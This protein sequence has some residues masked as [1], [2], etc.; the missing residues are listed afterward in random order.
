VGG[1]RAGL[2]W[3][4]ILS[5]AGALRNSGFTRLEWLEETRKIRVVFE[6]LT[7]W[8]RSVVGGLVERID[9]SLR[10]V[11][12]PVS[13]VGGLLRDVTR[14]RGELLAEN[15]ALRQQLIV[16]A[17]TVKN[18]K[19][20]P[21]ERGL[22]VLLARFAPHWRD[23]MLL[24][25]PETVLRWHREGFRLFW[26]VRSR[27]RARSTPRIDAETSEFIAR[28]ARENRLWGAERVRGELLKIG[29][30]VSKRTIQK[31]MRRVRGPAPWGQS[32]S[33]FL[34]NHMHQTWACDF[35]QL[36]DFWFRPIFAFFIIDLGARRV[37][38]VGVTRNPSTTWVAQ[39]IRNATPCGEGPRFLIRD[40]DDKFGI[41]FDRAAKGAGVRV[42]RTGVRA[43]RMNADCERFLG[44][45]R[46]DCVDH[47][48]VLGERHLE[49][50]LQ[51][52]CFRYFNQARPHQG[53][54]Q[55][56]PIGSANSAAGR[57]EV[58]SVSVL[59]GLHH[60]Y[61]RAA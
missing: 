11:T 34:R 7:Q 18:P 9:R 53:M 13:L 60:D 28:L 36:Y 1:T 35:L 24:V 14:S 2:S 50:V 33:T 5:A 16:V 48:L 30:Q 15:M 55:L 47:V 20:A 45:A 17:R 23:A 46:R 32:W 43:P 37:V 40:N 42:L 56:V 10:S 39:Q 25:K 61:Q 27:A 22:L 49:R 8:V 19:V 51:E 12:R 31:Y 6:M 58:V 59:N 4:P 3:L 44:S 57:G 29:V 21:V 52:Y 54:G 41:D 26:K 38:H